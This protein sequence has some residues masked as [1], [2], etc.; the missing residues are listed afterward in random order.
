MITPPLVAL[1]LLL[2]GLQPAFDVQRRSEAQRHFNAGEE[3]MRA[4]SW[5]VAAAEFKAAAA[6]E[7]LM[8]LAH[9]NLGQSYMALKRY[10]EAVQAYL[11]CREAVDTLNSADQSQA[12]EHDRE[13]DDQVRELREQIRRLQ[14]AKLQDPGNQIMMVEER[15]RLLEASRGRSGKRHGESLP[16]LSLALGSA[17]FRQGEL[18]DAEREY[19]AAVKASP[20]LGAAHNNLAV[21]YMLSERFKESHEA[22][23]KAEKAGFPV[24]PNL[25]RELETREQQAASKP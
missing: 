22:I 1:V 3:S 18:D 7:P 19:E 21:I 11:R 24:S 8:V 4:E 12:L 23:R 5:E 2:Q 16:E 17:Y 20:K 9:Y 14:S 13:I 15:I 25:K 6:L 10:P